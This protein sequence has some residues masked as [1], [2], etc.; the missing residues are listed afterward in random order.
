MALGLLVCRLWGSLAQELLHGT[1]SLPCQP[2]AT[3]RSWRLDGDRT[4]GTDSQLV[5][6][7][8]RGA[9]KLG[10]FWFSPHSSLSRDAGEVVNLPL[11]SPQGAGFSGTSTRSTARG[12][13]QGSQTQ[14]TKTF[15]VHR[16]GATLGIG[17]LALKNTHVLREKGSFR[18]GYCH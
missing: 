10:L 1:E 18:S 2:P 15:Q 12:F 8:S 17:T 9:A 11:S 13:A 7:V 16:G 3:A 4:S 5:S 6:S 14:A